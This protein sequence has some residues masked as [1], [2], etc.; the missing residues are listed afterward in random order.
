MKQP[1]HRTLDLIAKLETSLRESKPRLFGG[2]KDCDVALAKSILS[3]IEKV[4]DWSSIPNLF[5]FVLQ[6]DIEIAD[7]AGRCIDSLLKNIRPLQLPQLEERLGSGWYINE[8]MNSLHELKSFDDN[9]YISTNSCLAVTAVLSFHK[10]GFIREPAVKHL[11]ACTTGAEL[12]YLL[13]RLADWVPQVRGVA[14]HAVEQRIKSDYLHHFVN[15]IAL[16]DRL[17]LKQRYHGLA[18]RTALIEH[19]TSCLLQPTNRQIFLDG[20]RHKDIQVRRTCLTFARNTSFVDLGDIVD[21]GVRDKDKTNR[22]IA[23]EI[24][25]RLPYLERLKL[26]NQLLSDPSALIRLESLRFLCNEHTDLSTSQVMTALL[27]RS[28][29]VRLFARWKLKDLDSKIDFR[30]FYMEKIATSKNASEIAAA[31]SGLEETGAPADVEKLIPLMLHPSVSVQK[32]AIR[33][34]A[35]LDAKSYSDLF[36]Q[37]LQSEASGISRA[38][39]DALVSLMHVV[40]VD[41][42]WTIFTTTSFMHVK[43][44]LLR[45]IDH[46]SQWDRVGYFLLVASSDDSQ[47]RNFA[48][49][50]LQSWYRE[51]KTTYAYTK[52]T[53]KQMQL[54]AMGMKTFPSELP[55]KLREALDMSTRINT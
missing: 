36:I 40:S 39:A 35:K 51:F 16:L 49:D 8:R 30:Q 6:S 11:S 9:K 32:S 34:L 4:G 50:K 27:D 18:K 20:L 25:K 44:N 54:L 22:Q 46:T 45:L 10:N 31:A 15:N 12:P 5:Q 37:K 13:M 47:I 17:K 7:S 52:P 24:S 41:E 21:L 23:I 28:A 55:V 48:M 29:A 26:L 1:T 43:R 53:A 3:E 38:A 42:L 2:R 33:T 14:E 19:I